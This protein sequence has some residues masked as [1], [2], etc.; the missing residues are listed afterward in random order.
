MHFE[1]TKETITGTFLLFAAYILIIF[2]VNFPGDS[3]VFGIVFLVFA[4]LVL[5]STGK[6]KGSNP[7]KK[8]DFFNQ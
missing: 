8:K 1:K 6:R 2:Y 7:N 3:K 4:G 5:V